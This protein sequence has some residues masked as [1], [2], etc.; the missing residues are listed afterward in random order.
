MLLS[1]LVFTIN[2]FPQ[3]KKVSKK[4]TQKSISNS[5]T[6][7]RECDGGNCHF[8]IVSFNYANNSSIEVGIRDASLSYYFSVAINK[9][10]ISKEYIYHNEP[11]IHFIEKNENWL[12]SNDC[13]CT[14]LETGEKIVD[15]N[16]SKM[17]LDV[18]ELGKYVVE[19][20][21]NIRNK[22]YSETGRFSVLANL[23]S[24]TVNSN[25]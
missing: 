21:I 7:N 9:G 12:D 20:D 18:Y 3:T 6:I 13:F 19:S 24:F 14:H 5:F 11:N 4:V 25:K 22:K 15:E 23:R 8:E 2:A 17:L 10:N 16:L 1:S